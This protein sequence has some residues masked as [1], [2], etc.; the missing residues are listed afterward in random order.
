MGLKFPAV[1]FLLAQ[2]CALFGGTM[3]DKVKATHVLSCGVIKEEPDFTKA[4]AHGNRAAFDADFCKAI[5]VAV[6]GEQARLTLTAYP[7]QA[8]GMKALKNGEIALLPTATPD[9]SSA[10]AQSGVRFARTMIFDG[11]SFLVPKNLHIT[12]SNQ[13][14]GKK[15]CFLAETQTEENLHEWVAREKIDFV[16]FP[17]QEEGEMAAAFVTGNCSALAGDATHLAFTRALFKSRAKDFDILGDSIAM[18]PLAP[19]YLNGDAQWATI[20]NWTAEVLVQAEESGVTSANLDQMKKCSEGTVRRLVGAEAG[21]GR[22]V[23]LDE[24]WAARVIK[25]VGNYGEMF[26]RDLGDKSVLKMPRGVNALWTQG[27]L[28]SSWPVHAE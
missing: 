20:V 12:R 1:V 24:F 5:A 28:M 22:A 21:I 11:Q 27:G 6:L 26:D 23:G 17:F 19:A 16:P 8:S 7:D 2:G 15:V 25:A 13:L 9:L 4:D 18:D 3:L 14:S 10:S